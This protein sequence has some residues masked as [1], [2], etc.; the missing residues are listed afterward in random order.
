[1]QKTKDATFEESFEKLYQERK[2][3]E[4]NEEALKRADRIISKITDKDAREKAQ[5]QFKKIV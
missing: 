3:K 5:A 2:A 4:L 1:V